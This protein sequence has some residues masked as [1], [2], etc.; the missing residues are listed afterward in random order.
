MLAPNSDI[1][2][3]ILSDIQNNFYDISNYALVCQSIVIGNTFSQ[4]GELPDVQ[5]KINKLSDATSRFMDEKSDF[6]AKMISSCVS[7]QTL[8]AT[9]VES[10]TDIKN[11]EWLAFLALLLEQLKTN[12]EVLKGAEIAIGQA[13]HNI[14]HF[15][16]LIEETINEKWVGHS[17]NANAEEIATEICVLIQSFQSLAENINLTERKEE[18][19]HLQTIVTLE[20]DVIDENRTGVPFLS[21]SIALSTTEQHVYTI[22]NSISQKLDELRV[23]Q[24]NVTEN[25]QIIAMLKS[26]LKIFQWL[27][28]SFIN[29]KES[30][31]KLILIWQ[32]EQDKVESAINIIEKGAKPSLMFEL[33]TVDKALTAWTNITGF[34]IDL[35]NEGF[36]ASSVTINCTSKTITQ[37]EIITNC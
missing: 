4:L 10:S 1:T 17:S 15:E 21:F 25:D 34:A 29:L 14:A 23:L 7:Y 24:N 19:S 36:P 2:I 13:Y 9:I 18:K 22:L 20:Y 33:Q 37:S 16:F 11:D 26:S 27:G 8:L 6:I 28:N 12:L 32:Q 30:L 35:Q 3:G 31:A 5:E